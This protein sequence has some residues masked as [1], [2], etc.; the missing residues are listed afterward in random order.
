LS[1]SVE[2][3]VIRNDCPL[4]SAIQFLFSSQG[5]AT[6]FAKLRYKLRKVQKI[7]GKCYAPT[8]YRWLRDLK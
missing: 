1:A 4:R 8:S 3:L 5:G 2:L 6:I 7:G